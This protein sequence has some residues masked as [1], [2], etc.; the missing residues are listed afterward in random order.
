MTALLNPRSVLPLM[1]ALALLVL[2]W[3]FRLGR[4]A[5]LRAE[6]QRL[7]AAAETTGAHAEALDLFLHLP[8][9]PPELKDFLLD[10]SDA[11]ERPN[12]AREL[13]AEL[14]RGPLHKTEVSGEAVWDQL[15]HLASVDAD[16]AR[17]FV[18]TLSTG[19]RAAAFRWTEDQLAEYDAVGAEEPE[20]VK[21]EV[22]A[23]ARVAHQMA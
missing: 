1:V 12:F 21:R 6:T 2:F 9:A 16:A 3:L 13:V 17:L 5:Q 4:S 15:Q 10:A 7:N 8:D 20:V 14:G 18:K 19:I 11:L 23:A 22:Y